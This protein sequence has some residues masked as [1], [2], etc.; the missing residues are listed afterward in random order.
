MS[1]TPPNKPSLSHMV[2]NVRDIVATHAFYTEMLGFVQVGQVGEPGGKFDMRFY[3]GAG[4][5]HHDIACA[6]IRDPA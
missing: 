1:T 4:H 5:S 3:Q 2:I 6:Q